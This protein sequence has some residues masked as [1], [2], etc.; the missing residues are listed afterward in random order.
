MT[1]LVHEP[2]LHE[3]VFTSTATPTSSFNVWV[4]ILTAIFFYFILSWYNFLLNLYNYYFT[5]SLNSNFNCCPSNSNFNCS[6]NSS[7]NCSNK[8][9]ILNNNGN[10][11]NSRTQLF[12]SLA[13]AILWS[14]ITICIYLLLHHN[15]YLH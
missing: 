15:G 11:N 2:I 4:V 3:E 6:S 10:N 7:D 8:Y 14:I 13:F 9:I 12:A 5:P 1:T